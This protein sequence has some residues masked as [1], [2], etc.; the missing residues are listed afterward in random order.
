MNCKVFLETVKRWRY[1]NT[2]GPAGKFHEVFLRSNMSY[3]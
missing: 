2:F 3:F 1:S